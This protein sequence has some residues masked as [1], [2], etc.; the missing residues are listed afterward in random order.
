MTKENPDQKFEK[1][2]IASPFWFLTFCV[3]FV[4]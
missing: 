4:I 2:L 1:S 3:S